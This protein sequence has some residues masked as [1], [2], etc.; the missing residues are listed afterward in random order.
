[1][2]GENTFLI[3]ACN[4]MASMMITGVEDPKIGSMHNMGDTVTVRSQKCE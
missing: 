3:A 1:M 2:E 4:N